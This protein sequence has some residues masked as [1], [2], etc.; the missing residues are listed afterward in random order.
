LD[1]ARR[2]SIIPL[3][4]KLQSCLKVSAE[5]GSSAGSASSL[6]RKQRDN[7]ERHTVEE[8]ADARKWLEENFLDD[9]D[10]ANDEGSSTS[11]MKYDTKVYKPVKFDPGHRRSLDLCPQQPRELVVDESPKPLF[12]F[13]TF[14]DPQFH[15]NH[16]QRNCSSDEGD[17]S[18][19]EEESIKVDAATLNQQ[20]QHHPQRRVPARFQKNSKKLRMKRANTIDIPKPS[21]HFVSSGDESLYKSADELQALGRAFDDDDD[22]DGSRSNTLERKAQQKHAPRLEVKTDNDKKFAKFLEKIKEDDLQSKTVTYNPNAAGGA[23]WSNRFSYIKTAFEQGQSE[24]VGP[25]SDPNKFFKPIRKTASFPKKVPRPG[26]PGTL[27]PPMANTENSFRHALKSPFKPVTKAVSNIYNSFKPNNLRTP[28]TY[29]TPVQPLPKKQNNNNC[30]YY[31][32]YPHNGYHSEQQHASIPRIHYYVEKPTASHYV[33][34]A[35][36]PPNPNRNL[37]PEYFLNEPSAYLHVPGYRVQP[38]SSQPTSPVYPEQ[39]ASPAYVSLPPSPLLSRKQPPGGGEYYEEQP[40]HSKIMGQPQQAALVV[41]ASPTNRNPQQQKHH[42]PPPP[43]PAKPNWSKRSAGDPSPHQPSTYQKLAE[44]SP[45]LQNFA[46]NSRAPVKATSIMPP[47]APVAP[48]KQVKIVED[49]E[50]VPGECFVLNQRNKFE[51][52]K[53]P[54]PNQQH[55]PPQMNEKAFFK[56]VAS[57]VAVAAKR[58]SPPVVAQERSPPQSPVQM[59][60]VLQK[61]ESWHQMIMERMKQAKPPSP[62]KP[63][64]PRAKSTHNLATLPKQ[65]EATLSP[66]TLNVKKQ[67]VEQFLLRDKRRQK[68]SS[69]PPPPRAK[70]TANTTSTTTTTTSVKMVSKLNEDFKHVDEAFELLFNEASTKTM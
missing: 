27:A 47:P 59:P 1:T 40:A 41:V 28:K 12:A 44:K 55:L 20:Q 56:P 52:L 53:T 31:N 49:E 51:T 61:S 45:V 7:K 21:E 39:Y 2:A 8:L 18:S 34:P 66:E 5:S 32:T 70:E 10:G 42:A 16:Q 68:S 60:S 64:L 3:V 58:G 65:Y 30:N 22:D 50:S 25:A 36:P 43:L 38:V 57:N 11:S 4:A 63:K 23:Q 26:P 37:K 46:Q 13:R 48:K 33:Y 19:T 67:T 35:P 24:S 17:V 62:I 14:I 15:N 9:D 69:P 29:Y 6:K 54:Q